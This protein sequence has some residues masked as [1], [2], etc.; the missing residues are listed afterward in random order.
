MFSLSQYRMS[1]E[2]TLGL[3]RTSGEWELC[4]RADGEPWY[5]MGNTAIVFRIRHNGRIRALRCYRRPMRHLREIYGERS[6][7]GSCFSSL[8]PTAAYGSMS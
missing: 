6:S 2:D 7:N 8:G 5:A 3:T 1:L 4:R